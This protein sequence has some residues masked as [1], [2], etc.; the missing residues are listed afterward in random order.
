MDIQTEEPSRLNM[1]NHSSVNISQPNQVLEYLRKWGGSTSDA[2]LDPATQTFSLPAIQGLIGYRIKAGCAIVFGEPVC[3]P[4]ALPTLVPAF[5]LYCRQNGWPVIY[6][7]A[8]KNFA[9]WALQYVCKA[10]IEFGEEI[11][12]DPHSDPRS[13]E[14]VN[15]SLVRRKVRHAL[16]EGMT[17]QEYTTPDPKL[18]KAIEEVGVAWLKGRRGPQ[19]HISH[20]HL[21]ENRPGK[22]WFYAR[23][24]DQITG[25]A[26]L[27]Q[28]QAKNGWLL[29]H[30]M[31]KPTASHGTPELLVVTVLEALSKENCSY[32]TFGAVP[33]R[34]L[35]EIVGLSPFAA[36]IARQTYNA[37][38]G[39]FHLDGRKKFW[40]KF[41]PSSQTSYVLFSEPKIGFREITALLKALNAL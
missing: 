26:I 39:I 32:V 23:Q 5:H 38:R 27:N 31:F 29:N 35:G 34:H 28:L 21:F 13:H 25:V 22:R 18:E 4:S 19:F 17:V 33:S 24:N 9:D 10:K 36:W 20:I 37:V 1:E 15:G 40:E 6:I 14:G 3:A 2:I 12:I 16:K 30:L 11:C 7:I 41:H 8:S